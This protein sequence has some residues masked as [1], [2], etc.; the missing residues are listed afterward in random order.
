[1]ATQALLEV[2]SAPAL[3]IDALHAPGETRGMDEVFRAYDSTLIG[4]PE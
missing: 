2:A 1:M 3:T 4:W